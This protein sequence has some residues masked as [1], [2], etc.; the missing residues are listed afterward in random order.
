MIAL[1]HFT[2]LVSY[3]YHYLFFLFY[4]IC[5]VALVKKPQR[6]PLNMYNGNKT[7]LSMGKA[8]QKDMKLCPTTVFKYCSVDILPAAE[9]SL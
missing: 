6:I 4:M 2:V 1:V 9:S 3:N 7:F 5:T 8:A